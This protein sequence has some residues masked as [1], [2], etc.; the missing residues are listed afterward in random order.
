L[1]FSICT[2]P[3][4]FDVFIPMKIDLSEKVALVTGAS[5][6]IGK[7][8]ALALAQ[9]GAAVAV[10]Y[11][12]SEGLAQEVVREIEAG[13]G[14]AIAWR[15]DVRD[16]SHVEGMVEAVTSR[17]GRLDILVNN[18]GMARDILLLQM[19]ERDW[20]EVML[21]NL[22]GV[23]HCCKLAV[24]GMVMKKWG[25]I[26]NLSSVSAARG[27]KGRSNY[28]AS[29]GAI[30]A[31]TRSLASEVGS[32]G[33][34]VNAI[35]PGLIATDMSRDVLPF[36]EDWVRERVALRRAGRPEEVAPLAVFLASEGAGYI[37]GQ[38]FTVDGGMS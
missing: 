21:T 16:R 30:D 23:Y 26:I 28:A 5:R 29:K 8:I 18:A 32:K 14:K 3:F 1:H 35:A 7:A 25:R 22:W 33:V 31:F 17:Y 11:R 24:R 12:E 19:E 9:A 6:G 15:A 2:L 20:E 37:T 4:A 10:N 27:G 13:G 38:V 36:A 34:T